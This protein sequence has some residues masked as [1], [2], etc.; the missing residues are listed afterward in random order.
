MKK[1]KS[2]RIGEDLITAINTLAEK[3]RR[4][5]SNQVE[6]LLEDALKKL[7]ATLPTYTLDAFTQKLI[8]SAVETNKDIV[9]TAVAV[10]LPRKQFTPPSVDDVRGYSVEKGYAF[11]P[12]AF[13][14]HYESNG[15]KVGRNKM[16]SWKAACTTWGKRE[17]KPGIGR[18]QFKTSAEKTAERLRDSRDPIKAMNF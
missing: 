4:T 2:I 15:W 11:D 13:I 5:F 9:T 16:K 3:E 6:C 12:I 10:K 14:A 18:Q 17:S 8:S 1:L 7:V